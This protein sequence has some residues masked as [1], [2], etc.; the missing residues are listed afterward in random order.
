FFGHDPIL[1]EDAYQELIKSHGV[2][3]IKALVPIEG[4]TYGT[5]RQIEGRLRS[6]AE[7]LGPQ[8]VPHLSL[9]I[10]SGSWLSKLRAAPCF[11]GLQA[12]SEVKAPLIKILEKG[13]DFDAERLAIEALGFL[14][15]DEWAETLVRY[16]RTG[17]WK[18]LSDHKIETVS[19]YPF[20]KLSSY[21]LEA[22][23]RFVAKCTNRHE[24]ERIL[25]LLTDFME[26]QQSE[27]PYCYPDSY[28]L[29][30]RHS[31]EFNE[32]SVDPIISFW[33][34]HSEDW[35]QELCMHILGEIAPLR[36]AKFLLETA[37][38]PSASA[39][40]RKSASIALGEI[41][42]Q[43]AAQRLLNALRDPS[44]DKT[45]LHWAFSTLYAVPLDWS[46]TSDY[47]DNLL[48]Q[49][50]EWA[51]QL[52][53]SLALKGDNRCQAELIER[54][55]DNEPFN[56]W[57][58]ALAL[59]RLLGF[60][61]LTYLEYRAEDAGDTMER[62]AM[63]AAI[64]RAGD[65]SKA[66]DLHE[67]LQSERYFAQLRSVWKIEILDSFR[68][69]STFDT[70]AFP[71]WRAATQLGDRQLQYF[72]SFSPPSRRISRSISPVQIT[73]SPISRTK[74]FISYSSRDNQWLE[75]FQLMLSPLIRAERVD[76]WD[77]T[78]IKPGKWH[79]QIK[80]A[81]SESHVALFLV[82]A[83]F[84]ASE[85]IMQHELP[86]LLQYADERDVKILWVL[87][88]D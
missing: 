77:D 11:A 37:I 22:F 24:S 38:S 15:A 54:L 5:S 48:A 65:D 71:L 81:M 86:D 56:R 31:S 20:E 50:S 6:V 69:L 9:A 1:A 33:G 59:V 72:D 47:I 62:C 74:V 8:I 75:Q 19:R 36:A 40:V 88:E 66:R 39:S 43:H 14:G 32:W 13:G 26:L 64:V 52:R 85:F 53:Y 60:K 3:A 21:V 70:R 51:N 29:V 41:R 27:L 83:H 16:A 79:A 73:K 55:D 58:A 44:T 17:H 2:N 34:E 12:T 61:S 25:R 46:G 18:P 49:D 30:A 7:T 68:N 87:L 45:Y 28:Q 67:A 76:L 23:T 35:L 84:L 4:G 80:K 10:S 42:H 82:S 57:A 63:Y 78:K